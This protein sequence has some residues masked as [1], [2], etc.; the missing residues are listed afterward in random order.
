[1]KDKTYLQLL[2]CLFILI[3]IAMVGF[4]CAKKPFWGDEKSGYILSYHPS[5]GAVW[6]Y[7]HKSDQKTNME[8]MGQNIE[9]INKTYLGYSIQNQ[10]L[11]KGGNWRATVM[12]DSIDVEANAMGREIRPDLRGFIGKSF[13]LIFT[14]HGKELEMPG[15]DSITVD[16]GMMAGGKQSIK[17]FF[18]N[19]LSDLPDKPVKIGESWTKRDTTDFTQSGLK[20][21]VLSETI[22][23]LEGV[24]KMLNFD[25]LKIATKSK[26]SLQGSGSQMGADLNFEGEMEGTGIWYFA[27]KEGLTVKANLENFMEGTIV[28]SGPANMSMPINQESR[29]EI[30][31]K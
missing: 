11:D 1:M 13:T 18:R 25:C 7:E 24:E 26:A 8:Q 29:I 9:T 22:N 23:T 17:T 5:L 30:V 6:R 10:G 28:V 20:I 12:V 16:F 3:I 27:F 4:G 2:N 19:V 21:Q 15:A 31:L 14:K